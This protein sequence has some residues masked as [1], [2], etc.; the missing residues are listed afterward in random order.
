MRRKKKK[1]K[2]LDNDLADMNHFE[3]SNRKFLQILKQLKPKIPPAQEQVFAFWSIFEFYCA[4]SHK[5][6]NKYDANNKR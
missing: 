2:Q 6:D 1:K 5:K 4:D 3:L